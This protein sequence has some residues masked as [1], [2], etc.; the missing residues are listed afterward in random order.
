MV[1]S[2]PRTAAQIV[3]PGEEPRIFDDIGCLRQYLT[4]HEV[5]RDAAIFVADHR[6]GDWVSAAGAVYTLSKGRRTPM[7]SGIIAHASRASRDADAA[8]AGG[9]DVAVSDILR[10][11]A[12]GRGGE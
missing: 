4:R 3:A 5:A 11:D 7:G 12:P 10:E 6:T 2:D 9:D 1:A 8:S